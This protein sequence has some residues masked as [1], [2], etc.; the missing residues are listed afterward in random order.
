MKQGAAT[1]GNPTI[2]ESEILSPAPT[3]WI[4]AAISN[5]PSCRSTNQRMTA[6]WPPNIAAKMKSPQSS[7]PQNFQIRGG[8]G[9][10]GGGSTT[11]G[12]SGLRESIRNFQWDL[13]VFT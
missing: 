8:S 2:T 4:T 5:G 13:S 7:V 12:C 9:G 10:K 11:G 6:I 1:A 3:A